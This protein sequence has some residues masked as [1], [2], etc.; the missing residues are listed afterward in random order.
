M[1]GTLASYQGNLSLTQQSF[2]LTWRTGDDWSLSLCQG[3]TDEYHRVGFENQVFKAILK[4]VGQRLIHGM[5][6]MN[7][8]PL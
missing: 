4:H 1:L 6:L 8:S 5:L 7:T 2:S 3:V